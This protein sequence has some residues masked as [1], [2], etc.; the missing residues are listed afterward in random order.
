MFVGDDSAMSFGWKDRWCVALEVGGSLRY[1]HEECVDGPIVHLSVCSAHVV[2]T[3]NNSAM[4]SMKF[5]LH[6]QFG[7]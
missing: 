1:L 6:M 7:F 4:V 5:N 2:I 3:L